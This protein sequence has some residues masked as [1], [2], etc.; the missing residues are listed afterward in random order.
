MTILGFT[1][2]FTSC[3]CCGRTELKGTYVID[4][5]QGNIYYYGSSC[6][7]KAASLDNAK[8]LKKEVKKVEFTEN[9]K[10]L[11]ADHLKVK[12]MKS[13]LNKG[14]YSKDDF[15]TKFGDVDHKDKFGTW[16]T[17]GHITHYVN[18]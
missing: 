11:K 16:F 8:E 1:E 5:L 10:T 3:D 4:D 7:L 17:V 6:G 2:E 9:F 14:L 12:Q 18:F 15:F 13:A